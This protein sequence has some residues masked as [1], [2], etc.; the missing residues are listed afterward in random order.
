MN[1]RNLLITATLLIS[2]LLFAF[3]PPT[4]SSAN[5]TD[6]ETADYLSAPEKDLIREINLVR[7]NPQ[8]YVAHLEQMKKYY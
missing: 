1:P 7:A 8:Q 6:V 3:L 5:N 4:G 2:S